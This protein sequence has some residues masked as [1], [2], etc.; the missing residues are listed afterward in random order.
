[1]TANV[2]TAKQL[3]V[4]ATIKSLIAQNSVSPSVRLICKAMNVKSHGSMHEHINALVRAG[5]LKRDD[6]NGRVYLSSTC[7]NCGQHMPMTQR[8]P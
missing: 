4:F 1:M 5:L 8:A 7:P 3:E 6:R 2:L